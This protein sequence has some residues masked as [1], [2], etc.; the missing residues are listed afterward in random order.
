M[1]DTRSE[2]SG[3]ADEAALEPIAH[4]SVAE[5]VARGRAARAEVPRRAH[6]EWEPSPVRADPVELLEEQA[7][8]RVAELVP[9]RYGRM[10]VSPF[11]FFRGAAYLMAADLAGMPR[12]GLHAQLCGDAHLSNF[13]VFAAPDRRLV[14]DMNDFDETLPGPFEWDLKRLVASFAV[15]GREPWVRRGHAAAV[16]LAVGRAYRERSAASPRCGLRRLVLAY[17]RR[18]VAARVVVAGER[19]RRSSGSS[20]TWPRRGRRTAPAFAKLT[21]DRRR[22]AADRRA[23]P[24]CSSRSA[25][26]SSG[27]A[28]ARGRARACPLV[29]RTLPGRPPSP[30]R[31]VPLRR[32]G[33]QGGRRRQRRDAGVGRA[34]GR[35]RDDDPL[36]LQVKEAQASVLE[37]FLGKSE[38]A[39]HGERVVEGQ[40]LMQAASDIM[41]GWLRTDGID[42]VER[43]FYV[44]Q[45]WDAKGSAL[46]DVMEPKTMRLYAQVCGADAR[47][48]ARPLGRRDRDRGLPR[49]ERHLRPGDRRVRRGLR[50]SERTRLRHIE[51]GGRLRPD[52]RRDGA[53]TRPARALATRDR[54]PR[55]T[56]AG[57]TAAGSR[58]AHAAELELRVLQEGVSS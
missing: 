41:L 14:F 54:S 58:H 37:P 38:F 3:A 52:R 57:V 5:R 21:R 2:A 18:G 23:T 13:G 47:P 51:G 1:P 15:A 30:A 50:R 56:E 7:K 20:A 24:R 48:R 49:L 31:A 46:V 43:D 27:E 8:T 44:R 26:S 28:G 39:N 53:L 9:I 4:F 19:R 55:A 17:R 35:A 40:R 29:R 36:F 33:A 12:T 25:S 45:L 6:A 32:R 11:T 22:R 10:L 42:G 34:H 16:N